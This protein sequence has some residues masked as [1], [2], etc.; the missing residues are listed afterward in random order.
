MLSRPQK[1]EYLA[2]YRRENPDKFREWS[3]RNKE[4]RREYMRRW[5]EANAAHRA[6][7]YR[8]WAK[9]NKHIVN[10]LIAKRTASKLNATPKW[11]DIHATRSF[12]RE[13]ARMTRET[14][15]KH[16]VDHIVPLQGETVCGLHYA[17]NLQILTKTE[18]IRKG[19][20]LRSV[21]A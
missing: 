10:A 19:N 21:A 17:A 11:A 2:R 20:K 18:N 12:Y 1:L 8:S 15:I 5:Q 9:A 6:E 16:E 3:E 14:G 13:A 7:S 4:R